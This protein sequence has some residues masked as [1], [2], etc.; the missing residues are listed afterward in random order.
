MF[1]SGI[2]LQKDNCYIAT[3]DESGG[4]VKQ[5]RIDNVAEF[6]LDYFRSLSGSHTLG[7]RRRP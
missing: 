2:H 5:Q 7:A 4:I 1:Y 3:V 6:I